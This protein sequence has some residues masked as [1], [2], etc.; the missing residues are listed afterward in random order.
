LE[1]G[2]DSPYRDWFHVRRFPLR[3]YEPG[4][5]RNYLGWWGLKSLPKLNTSNPAVRRYL[6]DVARYWIDQGADGLGES[7]HVGR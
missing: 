6:L 1:N 5:A 4:Q 7:V 2:P 3:A